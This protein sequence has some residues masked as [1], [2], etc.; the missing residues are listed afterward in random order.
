MAEMVRCSAATT[1][2]PMGSR[3]SA[4]RSTGPLRQ[5]WVL[6]RVS[7]QTR[8]KQMQQ[9]LRPLPQTR[10]LQHFP[11]QQVP[12]RWVRGS[13]PVEGPRSEGRTQMFILG[14]KIELCRVNMTTLEGTDWALG[15]MN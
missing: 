11:D 10:Q 7:A 6:A 1:T 4:R 8:L 14:H 5:R 9:P 15:K 12:R 3:T 13:F 2:A